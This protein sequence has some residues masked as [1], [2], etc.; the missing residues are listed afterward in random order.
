MLEKNNFGTTDV[1][2]QW[3]KDLKFGR[4]ESRCFHYCYCYFFEFLLQTRFLFKFSTPCG[5]QHKTDRWFCKF[6]I[7]NLFLFSMRTCSRSLMVHERRFLLHLDSLYLSHKC[8]CVEIAIYG[9]ATTLITVSDKTDTSM[10]KIIDPP[11]V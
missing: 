9:Y 7:K 11:F 5:N 1:F 8:K 10:H 6:L 3:L 4:S 2:D